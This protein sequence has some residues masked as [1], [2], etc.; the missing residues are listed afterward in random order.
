MKFIL[1]P[2]CRAYVRLLACRNDEWRGGKIGLTSRD[3]CAFM[4]MLPI[5]VVPDEE[6]NPDGTGHSLEDRLQYQGNYRRHTE[7][8]ED[9]I[10]PVGQTKEQGPNHENSTYDRDRQAITNIARSEVEAGLQFKLL[11]AY[12]TAFRHTH[13]RS[14]VVGVGACEEIALPAA[15]TFI[16]HHAPQ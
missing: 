4:R 2:D 3:S 9:A 7:A 11:S 1:E 12:G 5:P 8:P 10:V 13:G 6:G 14:E 16:S 15:G